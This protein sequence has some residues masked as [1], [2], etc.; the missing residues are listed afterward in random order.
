MCGLHQVSS[1]GVAPHVMLETEIPG[2]FSDNNFLALPWE[3][4]V[5]TF[6]GTTNFFVG[7]LE[8]SL[9]ITTIADTLQQATVMFTSTCK[10]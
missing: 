6:T 8:A 4:R 2:T 5:M 7:D 10:A 9:R 1:K 3:P